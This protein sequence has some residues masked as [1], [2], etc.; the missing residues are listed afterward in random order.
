M[1]LRASWRPGRDVEGL[2]LMSKLAVSNGKISVKLPKT[3]SRF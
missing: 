1:T 3:L 2:R